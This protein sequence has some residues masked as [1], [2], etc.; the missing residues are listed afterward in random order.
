MPPSGTWL[1]QFHFQFWNK[2]AFWEP[3][4]IETA[5]KQEERLCS[6]NIL[7]APW[8][9]RHKGRTELKETL[10]K[11]QK[12]ARTHLL[13]PDF[14]QAQLTHQMLSSLH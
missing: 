4:D 12:A 11:A 7:R 8:W 2:F 9:L 5:L 6:T 3:N 13:R 14:N 10:G 1:I